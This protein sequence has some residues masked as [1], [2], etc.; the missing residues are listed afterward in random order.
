MSD[1]PAMTMAAVRGQGLNGALKTVK[2]VALTI[3]FN[4]EA[5]VVIVSTNFASGHEIILP[6]CGF[7]FDVGQALPGCGGP[8]FDLNVMLNIRSR[9]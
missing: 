3:E 1:N 7:P 9:L 2:D 8:Q 4:A 5:L 6:S